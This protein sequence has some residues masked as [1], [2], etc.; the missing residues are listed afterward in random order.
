MLQF[1]AQQRATV[2][3]QFEEVIAADQGVKAL[4][5]STVDGH[6]VV[7]AGL[8]ENA[9]RLAAITSS[10]LGLAAALA[11]EAGQGQPQF[12][13]ADNTEGYVVALRVNA[14][15]VLAGF[16]DRRSSLGMLLSTLRRT[17]ES[18]QKGL[19]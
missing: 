3:T 7:A 13:I 10:V 1:S 11:K 16:A 15:L 14:L 4:L 6:A 5:L 2:E 8:S 19:E 9:P 12:M 18:L 17:A